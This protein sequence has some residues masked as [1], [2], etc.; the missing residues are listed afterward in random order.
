MAPLEVKIQS[1]LH[2]SQAHQFWSVSIHHLQLTPHNFSSLWTWILGVTYLLR[3]EYLW[4]FSLLCVFLIHPVPLTV[5]WLHLTVQMCWISMIHVALISQ[6][7]G[8]GIQWAQSRYHE[9]KTPIGDLL[10][11]MSWVFGRANATTVMDMLW[12][13]P[14]WDVSWLISCWAIYIGYR[15]T[16]HIM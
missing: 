10:D 9:F 5:L 12:H 6:F 14:H 1:I 13:T 3:K 4:T 16:Y 8:Q 11:W 2:C 7:K 15:P